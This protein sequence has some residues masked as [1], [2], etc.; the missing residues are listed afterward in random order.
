MTKDPTI[1]KVPDLIKSINCSI[2]ECSPY[3]QFLSNYSFFCQ[4]LQWDEIIA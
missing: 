1:Y 2:C 3:R 4:L